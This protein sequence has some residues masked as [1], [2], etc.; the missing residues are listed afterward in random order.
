[1]GPYSKS[2]KILSRFSLFHLLFPFK[3][4]KLLLGR[5]WLIKPEIA[6]L[7]GVSDLVGL[8]QM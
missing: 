1:M 3:R 6:H 5:D 2:K 7:G 4:M 8:K